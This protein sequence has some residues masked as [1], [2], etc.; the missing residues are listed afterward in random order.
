MNKFWEFKGD[1]LKNKSELYLDGEISSQTWWG[2]EVTPSAFLSELTHMTGDLTV[3][4][5]SPGGD[6]FAG[7]TIYNALKDYHGHV[8]VKVDGLAA[9]IASIIAMAGDE[10]IMSPGSMMM[11]HNP[12]STIGGNADELR[13][14]A[15][16]LDQ[17]EENLVP[18]YSNRTGLSV[19]EIK[20][21]LDDETWLSA[22]KA[23][24]LGFATRV[25]AAKVEDKKKKKCGVSALAS[26]SPMNMSF[27]M[28]ATRSAMSD[29][30]TKF[31]N[32]RKDI[33]MNEDELKKAEI[34]ADV[35]E[36]TV[37][38]TE[39][40]PVAEDAPAETEVNEPKDE[41]EETDKTET[42][43]PVEGEKT[44]DENTEEGDN[45]ED[46]D[47]G[48]DLVDKVEETIKALKDENAALK[49]EIEALKNANAK[50][51]AKASAQNE[52]Q[53]RLTAV[54]NMAEPAD[55][56]ENEGGKEDTP[57][58]IYGNA[59]EEAFKEMN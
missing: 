24:E 53:A 7:V 21:L 12:W 38:D 29:L 20:Q 50:A 42:E 23:V 31:N 2:D 8:V 10:I 46:I 49:A 39:D 34:E 11:I 45:A 54:L 28:S 55:G 35:V 26:F 32:S 18:I 52:L 22:E 41:V 9:S 37:E 15:D 30:I 36:A 56:G 14:A 44:E 57:V 1:L 19:E 25:E 27:S 47:E 59:L 16:I 51:N 17:I 6:V 58:D 13:E 5:N 40:A 33:Q 4:I 43:A 48:K 3:H